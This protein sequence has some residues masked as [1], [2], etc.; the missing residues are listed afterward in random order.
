M[1]ISVS[2]WHTTEADIDASIAA[3]LAC[4]DRLRPVR[5]ERVSAALAAGSAALGRPLASPR[6]LQGSDRSAVLR[7]ATRERARPGEGGTVIVKTYPPDGPG[8][9][10]FAAEAAGL[11]LTGDAGLGPV[12]LAADPAGLTVVMSDLGSGPSLAD[13]L[14]DGPPDGGERAA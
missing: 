3:V 2:A 13:L 10:S 5:A 1:R 7:C 4:A 8:A 6:V 11:V 12:L 14:L 9:G